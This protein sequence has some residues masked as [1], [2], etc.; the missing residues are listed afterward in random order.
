MESI[1]PLVEFI[2]PNANTEQFKKDCDKIIKIAE[3]VEGYLLGYGKFS[4]IPIVNAMTVCVKPLGTENKLCNNTIIVDEK[5]SGKSTL[6]S[7]IATGNPIRLKKLPN[8]IYGWDMLDNKKYGKKFY[9]YNVCYHDDLIQAVEGI[10]DKS[11]AQIDE[12]LMEIAINCQ[13]KQLNRKMECNRVAFLFA[14]ATPVFL[15]HFEPWKKN[16]FT[17]RFVPIY[18]PKRSDIYKDMINNYRDIILKSKTT[19]N[20]IQMPNIKLPF[21]GYKGKSKKK[22]QKT[23]VL[24][25]YCP[26]KEMEA[27]INTICK[28]NR[29][30]T[31]M[32]E[33]RFKDYIIKFMQANALINDRDCVTE[34]DYWL[35]FELYNLNYFTPPHQNYAKVIELLNNP[36]NENLSDLEIG[37]L[38]NIP[39]TLMTRGR[40]SYEDGL[41]KIRPPY[42]KAGV[43][44]DKHKDK[45]SAKKPIER[46]D[47][48]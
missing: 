24:I 1:K 33:N 43:N 40:E 21:E 44:P 3:Q 6:I 45:P 7:M 2:S 35:F 20:P 48:F 31:D 10:S 19:D 26:T 46:L 14:I 11:S 22:I 8:K 5:G 30:Q 17:E 27:G 38:Y 32:T 12:A 23:D 9:D 4:I 29:K 41:E 39:R 15:D 47:G 37:K 42:F 34:S 25:K 13:Y 18:F 16:T 28:L 36:S